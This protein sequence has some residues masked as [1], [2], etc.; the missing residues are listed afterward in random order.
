MYVCISAAACVLVYMWTCKRVFIQA[1]SVYRWTLNKCFR[2]LI[3]NFYRHIFIAAKG[4]HAEVKEEVWQHFWSDK[5]EHGSHTYSHTPDYL[6]GIWQRA[7]GNFMGNFESCRNIILCVCFGVHPLT[8]L[9]K[10]SQD[11]SR[12]KAVEGLV[13]ETKNQKNDASKERK[14]SGGVLFVGVGEQ[15]RR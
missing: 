8:P 13:G 6:T 10:R 1:L 9:F 2:T 7:K 4:C 5:T 3:F 11:R 15:R 12:T 14:R